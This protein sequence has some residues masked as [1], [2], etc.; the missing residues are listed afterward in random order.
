MPRDAY[1]YL[2]EDWAKKQKKVVLAEIKQLKGNQHDLSKLYTK[3][4]IAA[5]KK[6]ELKE[7]KDELNEEHKQELQNAKESFENDIQ[8][9]KDEITHCK[10]EYNRTK[11]RLSKIDKETLDF[12]MGELKKRWERQWGN[13]KSKKGTRKNNTRETIQ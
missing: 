2:Q 4:E 10:N 9:Y 3:K 7:L 12:M 11:K 13:N 1:S 6:K 5:I 8:Y